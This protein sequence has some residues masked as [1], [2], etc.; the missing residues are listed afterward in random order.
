MHAAG[1]LLTS[2]FA[3]RLATVYPIGIWLFCALLLFKAST[4]ILA[5]KE[6]PLTRAIAFLYREYEPEKFWWGL[7]E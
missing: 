7:I 4:T 3:P 2:A 1:R 5:G 6:T